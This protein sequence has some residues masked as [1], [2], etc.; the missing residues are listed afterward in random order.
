MLLQGGEVESEDGAGSEDVWPLVRRLRSGEEVIFVADAVIGS[1]CDGTKGVAVVTVGKERSVE[2]GKGEADEVVV[3]VAD[4]GEVLE[5]GV[6]T[7]TTV[8]MLGLVCV[9]ERAGA[10]GSLNESPEGEGGLS[11]GAIGAT[12]QPSELCV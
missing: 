8:L 3:S 1:G 12:R 10:D 9:E 7:G 2:D 5:K 4:E 6:K 11:V